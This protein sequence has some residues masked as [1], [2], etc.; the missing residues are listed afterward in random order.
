MK[1][2]TK[3]KLLGLLFIVI[4]IVYLLN[5]TAGFIEF[6]PDNL[7]VVGNIDEGGAGALLLKGIQLTIK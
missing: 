6:L 3:N 4:A 7:P 1:K 2:E 5:L